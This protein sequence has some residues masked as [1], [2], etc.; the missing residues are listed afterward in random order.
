MKK[1]KDQKHLMMPAIFSHQRKLSRKRQKSNGK[2][3]TGSLQLHSP[4]SHPRQVLIY[5]SR[6]LA[7][8][9]RSRSVRRLFNPAGAIPKMPS[10]YCRRNTP[11]IVTREKQG[12]AGLSPSR[13]S[14]SPL[15][16]SKEIVAGRGRR[17]AW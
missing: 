3:Q 16:L 17:G 6:Y 13:A 10:T 11:S 8:E 15:I 2:R 4:Q 1:A 9:R 14:L 7:L 12:L 5:C